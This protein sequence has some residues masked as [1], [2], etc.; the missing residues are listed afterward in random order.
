ME[1]AACKG[2]DFGMVACSFGVCGA[3]WHSTMRLL[4]NKLRL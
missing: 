2:Q 4:V 1:V 3:A